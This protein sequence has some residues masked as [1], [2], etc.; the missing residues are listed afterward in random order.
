ML[1]LN[2]AIE[3]GK[4]F[5]VVANEIK[6]LSDNTQKNAKDIMDSLKNLTASMEQLIS[7]SNEGAVAI[8][9]T[10]E[11]IKGSEKLLDNII[12]AESEVQKMYKLYK[13]LKKIIYTV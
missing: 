10:T 5:A 9:K 12:D 11:V 4:G 6:K 13:N 1:S 3:A 7:K 8:S 2:A